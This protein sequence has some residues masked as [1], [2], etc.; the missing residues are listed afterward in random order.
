MLKADKAVVNWEPAK[1]QWVIRVQ[2]GEE[3]IKRPSPKTPRDAQED[4]LRSL[5]VATAKDEGYELDI[6]SVTVAR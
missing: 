2:S 6:S 3:V 1:K 5:A 4:V